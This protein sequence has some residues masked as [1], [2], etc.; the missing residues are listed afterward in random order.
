MREIEGDARS[1]MNL[2]N[3]QAGRKVSHNVRFATTT[4]PRLM[5]LILPSVVIKTG[6]RS[7]RTGEASVSCLKFFRLCVIRANL[8]QHHVLHHLSPFFVCPLVRSLGFNFHA[9]NSHHDIV[10]RVFPGTIR[11]RFSG[12]NFNF[13]PLIS[14]V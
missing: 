8:S 11:R 5:M 4:E 14:R 6:L 10:E 2:H 1:E 3:N 12:L 9:F 7:M 13:A